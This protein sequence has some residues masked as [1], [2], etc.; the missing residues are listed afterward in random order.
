MRQALFAMLV[1]ASGVALAETAAVPA[2][3]SNRQSWLIDHTRSGLGA[4]FFRAFASAWRAGEHGNLVISVDE[5]MGQPFAHRIDI[6]VGNRLLLQTQLYPSQRGN[7]AAMAERAATTAALRLRQL[8]APAE[9][10]L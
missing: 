9:V 6:W 5:Q 7:L 4:E 1:L 3:E 10:T 8:Q 2:L